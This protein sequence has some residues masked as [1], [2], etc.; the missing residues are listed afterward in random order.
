MRTIAND[1]TLIVDIL[2]RNQF[3]NIIKFEFNSLYLNI[4]KLIGINNLVWDGL[5]SSGIK[6]IGYSFF[7][8]DLNFFNVKLISNVL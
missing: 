5:I 1:R 4:F 6:T 8:S 7:N 2:N 3:E